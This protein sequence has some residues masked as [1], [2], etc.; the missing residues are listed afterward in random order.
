MIIKKY[1]FLTILL[2]ELFSANGNTVDKVENKRGRGGATID[3]NKAFDQVSAFVKSI[4]G[5][6]IARDSFVKGVLNH[7]SDF[8]V[9]ICH[10]KHLVSSKTPGFDP[11][12]R[13]LECPINKFGGT[14]GYEVYVG[15]RGN[16]WKATNLGDGG[17]INWGFSGSYKREGGSIS[18]S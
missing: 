2:I 18:F 11:I 3:I 17:W 4:G 13:H 7:F 8:N 6:P 14:I 16:R 5:S 10:P 9:F 12:H 1:I 15:E